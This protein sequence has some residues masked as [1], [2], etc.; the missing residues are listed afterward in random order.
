MTGAVA[1][2]SGVAA[3]NAAA[4]ASSTTGKSGSADGSAGTLT[5]SDFLQ[6][7]TAQLKYQT[8][9]NPA[10]PTQMASEFAE[11]STVDGINQLNS[12]V[13][14]I[15]SGAAAGQI[16]QAAGLVGKQVAAS[17]NVLTPDAS[18]KATGAF[19]LSGAAQD[20]TVSIL[21]PNGTVAGSVDLGAQSAGQQVFTWGGGTAGTQ[22]S[23]QLHAV[24]AA[25]NA[26]SA[27]SYSVYTVAG[28]NVSGGTPT[29]NVQGTATPLDISAI[30]TVLGASS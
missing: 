6:L 10:D 25:G 12:S 30:Q 29:L 11:I 16:A 18:G 5:Q 26:V 17:G 28:V 24:D 4:V 7:L 8:P 22:Y 14:S 13:S 19:N 1:S 23:Y 27:T 3:A 20:V 9:N 2:S 15:Q 21:N